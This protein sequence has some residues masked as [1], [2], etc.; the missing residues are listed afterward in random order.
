ML[1]K[2]KSSG[3]LIRIEDWEQLASPHRQTVS[4]RRQAGE[5]EQDTQEYSKQDLSFPSDE[6]LPRCWTDPDYKHV[7][8]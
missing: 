2:E 8:S 4:G 3:D 7:L 5:E 6:D 1:I